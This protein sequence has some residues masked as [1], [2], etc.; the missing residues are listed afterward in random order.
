MAATSP[1][2]TL[3]QLVIGAGG[4]FLAGS[5]TAF[6]WAYLTVLTGWQ[7]GYLAIGIGFCV[8]FGARIT[9]QGG[10]MAFQIMSACLAMLAC[11]V[12]NLLVE[13]GFYA[14]DQGF[15]WLVSLAQYTPYELLDYTLSDTQPIDLLFYA[16]AA[17]AGYKY[18]L[19]DEDGGSMPA[20]LSK[21]PAMPLAIAGYTLAFTFL[22]AL[23]VG[24]TAPVTFYHESGERAS[25]G[26]Y[27]KGKR[28]DKWQYFNEKG[29]LVQT[30]YF[31]EGVAVGSWTWLDDS[32]R[33]S[34]IMEHAYGMEH[35]LS[36]FY[37]TNGQIADSGHYYLGR[38][39]GP[40]KGFYED[41]TKRVSGNYNYG[42]RTGKWVF[43]HPNGQV[44]A[45]AHYLDD[46]L[47]GFFESY[48]ANGK[49]AMRLVFEED[50]TKIIDVFD[51]TGLVLVQNGR[52][53]YRDV[54]TD[55]LE[56][57][58]GNVIDSVSVGSWREEWPLGWLSETVFEG[59]EKRL[60]RLWRGDEVLVEGGSGTFKWYHADSSLRQEGAIVAGKRQ[61][62]WKK[63]SE[64][65]K[66][67]AI[68]HYKK[69][70]FHGLT[71]GFSAS[72]DTTY[73]IHF[74][75]DVA[76]GHAFWA[77]DNGVIEYEVL[78]EN[79]RKSGDE[80]FYDDWGNLIKTETY[81]ANVLQKI[82][83]PFA[84]Y[85]ERNPKLPEKTL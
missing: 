23:V 45:H 76:E 3:Q 56:I 78:Y 35:G 13:V 75:E 5:V 57:G 12:G 9:G 17:G 61:G 36:Q 53:A 27:K 42:D 18:S 71:A 7:I 33:V 79:G 20:F 64:D 28:I 65:G 80:R 22:A 32:S 38:M 15:D 82:Y 11:L 19:A 72:G 21:I 62:A 31:K 1:K 58:M 63:Y 60:V 41:G 24:Y 77:Y 2:T 49:A 16:L 30:G 4:G 74:V 67:E 69:G 68:S 84:P 81:Q 55:W 44:E 34:K 8:A 66:V 48:H 51:S 73:R 29:K 70:L 40:W 59:D 14:Q 25:D 46:E 54:Q 39:H 26:F 10:S 83:L 50:K 52:G 47:A 6:V 37:H 85:G 43:Y